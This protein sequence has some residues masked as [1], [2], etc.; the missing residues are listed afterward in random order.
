MLEKREK[1]YGYLLFILLCASIFPVMYLGR[2][3]HPTGDDYYYGAA[4]KLALEETGSLADAVAEAAK[5]VAYEY[6]HW[7]GTYSAMF[8]M[9]LPP[10]VFGDGAYH[11]LTAVL[12]LLFTSGVFYL[13][14]PVVCG[15]MKGTMHLWVI[16]SS[17]L[18]LLALQTVP[19]QGETLFWYNGSMYYTGFFA[20]TMFFFGMMIRYLISGKLYYIPILAF[21]AFFLAGGNYVSLLP[22]LLLLASLTIVLACRRSGKSMGTGIAACCMLA[23]LLI[24]AAAPGNQVRQSGMWQIPA[25][26]AV[27]K[28]LVQG[29]VYMDAWLG[30][31]WLI[32]AILL[33]PFLWRSFERISFRFRYPLI[34]LGYLYGIFCSMS[35]P[36]FYTMNST[37]PARAVAIVYYAFILFSFAGYYYLLGYLYH[38]MSKRPRN[39][40][41]REAGLRQDDADVQKTGMNR[42]IDN[43]REMAEKKWISKAYAAAAGSCLLLLLM[44]ICSGAASGCTV[45]KAVKLLTNGEAAAYEQEYQ[46]RLRIFEDDAIQDVV[47]APYI[48]QPDML[49]VGDFTDDTQ[50]PTNLRAAQYF[51]KNSVMVDYSR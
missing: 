18:S 45:V 15:W 32:A 3:N 24:S 11:L 6:E 2:Y 51:H 33:T 25:W 38:W 31:W 13:M 41:S 7:Q 37:G 17:V 34:V 5:G 8:L 50:N 48:H 28:S 14:K 26:K 20:V 42:K 40:N 35:C 10:N 30:K 19:S 39:E 43:G 4:A 44:Q 1:I 29:I 16:C 47:F 23:G 46:E 49:Y 9:Y 27:L 12:I 22:S 36:T 21:L